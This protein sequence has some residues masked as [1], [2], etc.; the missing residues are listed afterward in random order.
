MAV[1]GGLL[2]RSSEAGGAGAM[3]SLNVR[4]AEAPNDRLAY[5][6]SAGATYSDP[7][8]RPLGMIPEVPTPIEPAVIV[9]GGSYDDVPYDNNGTLQPKLDLRIDHELDGE[10]R[11][12]YAAG[13]GFTEGI[14]QTPIGPFDAQRGTNLAYGQVSYQRG[15]L[16]AQVFANYLSGEAPSLISVDADGDPL[17]IDFVNGVYDL[18]VGYSDLYG[19]RH[20]MSFGGNIRHNTF[21]LSIAPNAEDRTQA[22]VYVQDEIDLGTLKLA[23]AARVD[24]FTNL[25]DLN[26]SPR[27]AL[28][29]TPIP[30]HS[31]KVSAARAFRAPSAIDNYLELSIIGGYFPVSE[32]DPRLEEDFGLIVNTWGNP[33]LKAETIENI[34][35]GYSAVLSGGRTRIDLNAYRSDLHDKISTSPP[36][37]A[38]I[39]AGV[40]PYYTSD[41][42]P[43]GWPLN[44]IVIDFLGLMDIRFPSNVLALN[45]GSVRDEGIEIAVSHTFRRGVTLFGN[46]SYQSLPEL[47]DPV[48]DPDRPVSDTVH[49][50]PENRFNI[51]ATYNGPTY[52]GN[53]TINY[54]DEAFFAQG[55]QP[56]YYGFSD[57]YTITNLSFGRRWQGGRV[58]TSLKVVNLLDEE[59]KQHVFGDILR[60]TVMFE[61]LFRF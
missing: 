38:L 14:I 22:G 4:W 34:E 53:L 32:F 44:P 57:S 5:R 35:V 39:A 11:I 6:I 46:Y 10:G 23:L 8:Q 27:A 3:G 42:P 2:S 51:G 58:T 41:N 25:D 37:E 43:P 13:I 28:I 26:F 47:L 49:T 30:G 36:K 16:R 15:G 12:T 31:F 59:V 1:T 20:L 19:G 52:L 24:H 61:A 55:V 17:R 56:F 18:D 9:G 60:R 7:L 40:D 21:D 48:G 50:P 54:S 29:W 45:I 33:D